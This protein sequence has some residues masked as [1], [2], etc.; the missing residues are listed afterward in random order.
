M[1]AERR[2]SACYTVLVPFRP[3]PLVRI[4]EPFDQRDCLW[5]LKWDGFRVL[6]FIDGH[7]CRLVSRAGHVFRS[8][9]Q[10]A[11]ELAHAVRAREAVL[12]GEIVCLDPDARSNYRKLLPRRDQ[13]YY[14]AFD[15]HTLAA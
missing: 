5:E 8:W 11:E 4:P 2:A 14:L 7:E 3:M 13:P 10:L 9:P 6:A 12:D 1:R 15:I